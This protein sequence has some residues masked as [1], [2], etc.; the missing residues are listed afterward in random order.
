MSCQE[1]KLREPKVQLS[2]V[3]LEEVSEEDFEDLVLERLDQIERA[4]QRL[5]SALVMPSKTQRSSNYATRRF[6]SSPVIPLQSN[7]S[8]L[9]SGSSEV[10]PSTIPTSQAAAPSPSDT[11]TGPVSTTITV[12]T[13]QKSLLKTSPMFPGVSIMPVRPMQTIKSQSIPLSQ[14][15]LQP[16]TTQVSPTTASQ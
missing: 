6:S 4:L 14:T 12:S 13:D 15:Q 5:E 8:V 2:D 9:Q 10:T 1:Q 11:T 7:P 3:S 16:Q